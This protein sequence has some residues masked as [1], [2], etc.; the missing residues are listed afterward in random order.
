MLYWEFRFD[1]G[2]RVNR[3]H[4]FWKFYQ[5]IFLSTVIVLFV[6]YLLRTRTYAKMSYTRRF[7]LSSYVISLLSNR[8]QS[9]VIWKNIPKKWPKNAEKWLKNN[10]KISKFFPRRVFETFETH[11]SRTFSPDSENG[12][13]FGEGAPEEVEKGA[14]KIKNR[15][16]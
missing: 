3:P 12:L 14:R 2:L 10:Q 9:K 4:R 15:K 6:C 1:W 11:P 13:H 7:L 16:F 8:V 5:N